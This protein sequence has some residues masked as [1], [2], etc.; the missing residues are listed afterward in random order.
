M[1]TQ[2]QITNYKKMRTKFYLGKAIWHKQFSKNFKIK[3][4]QIGKTTKTR[5]K[6]TGNSKSDEFSLSRTYKLYRSDTNEYVVT[7]K[8]SDLELLK[9]YGI[10]VL[11][12]KNGF[13]C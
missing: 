8:K 12:E 9:R 3:A 2:T 4:P 7:I 11:A 10:T 5:W 6:S 13:V 1:I